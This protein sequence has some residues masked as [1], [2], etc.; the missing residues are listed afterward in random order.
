MRIE[1]RLSLGYEELSKAAKKE[2]LAGKAG[3]GK[4]GK[5]P[6]DQVSL[7]SNSAEVT[8]I[9]SK[10]KSAPEIRAE[11]VSEIKKQINEGVYDFSGRKVAEKLV[12]GALNDLF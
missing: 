2:D 7:S 11:K 8:D 5:A 1:D 3:G 12:N 6:E 4:K 10:V 9:I